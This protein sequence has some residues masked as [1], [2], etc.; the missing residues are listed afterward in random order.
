MIVIVGGGA[1]G[2][3]AA[4]R[5]SSKREKVLV[6]EKRKKFGGRIKSMHVDDTYLD[7]GAWR[8]A[9]DH[10]L[11]RKFLRKKDLIELPRSNVPDKQLSHPHISR[12]A[13]TALM[14][15]KPVKLSELSA[16]D[17]TTGYQGSSAGSAGTSRHANVKYFAIADGFA[18]LISRLLNKIDELRTEGYRIELHD[19]AFVDHISKGFVHT[20]KFKRPLKPRIIILAVPPAHI[21]H[22][23]DYSLH[24]A[25]RP[26]VSSIEPVPLTRIHGK[27][28]HDSDNVDNVS[29]E[30]WHRRVLMLG[31]AWQLVSY[32]S[33]WIARMWNELHQHLGTEGL[34]T[35][36]FKACKSLIV[37][38]WP[39][40][41]HRWVPCFNFD[42]TRVAK[43]S[44][45]V[46]EGVY[47]V[48]EA[49][50]DMQGWT[51][52]AFRSVESLLNIFKEENDCITGRFMTYRGRRLDVKDWA[53]HHP[54][55]AQLIIDHMDEDITEIFDRVH[56]TSGAYRQLLSLQVDSRYH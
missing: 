42:S 9:D 51:E 34:R 46:A 48:G 5:M 38:H 43:N 8:V 22:A 17:M 30:L 12:F 19:S 14:H 20:E 56:S 49:V 23:C 26:V 40:G 27:I 35:Q 18:K 10:K 29:D 55:S 39:E 3:Y 41:T 54:G 21:Q 47:L 15:K 11:V 13:Y 4:I 24:A 37:T 44:Q 7:L 28:S 52:G 31:R 25:L 53:Q 6:L 2:L 16:Y 1:S 33:G 32:T 36:F 50:S 45:V